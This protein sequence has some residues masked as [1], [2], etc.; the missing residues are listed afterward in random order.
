[1]LWFHRH[2]TS[3]SKSDE[4]ERVWLGNLLPE[5]LERNILNGDRDKL[6]LPIHWQELVVPPQWPTV[7]AVYVPQRRACLFALQM[8]KP[9]SNQT[10]LIQ[11]TMLPWNGTTG[12]IEKTS[13]GKSLTGKEVW[14]AMKIESRRGTVGYI[15]QIDEDQQKKRCASTRIVTAWQEL[16][17]KFANTDNE[18]T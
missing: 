5:D 8:K 17:N 14:W 11:A 1:M 3:S 2:V 6:A 15:R 18:S 13:L 16:G 4:N 10:R 7:R 9:I 12:Q